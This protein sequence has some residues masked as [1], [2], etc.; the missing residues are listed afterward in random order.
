MLRV[1]IV[2]DTHAGE[3]LP[4]I[5]PEIHELLTG[6]EV[7]L[8]AGD[9]TD[10]S[11]LDGLR[12]VAPVVAVCGDHDRTFAR[13]RLPREHVLEIAGR[14]IG[15]T[16][17]NRSR[18]VEYLARISTLVAGRLVD[19]GLNR[20]LLRRFGP[21][22][23]IVY[24]H[25]HLPRN[26]VVGRTLIFSPGAGFTPEHDPP[27]PWVGAAG[28]AT[29]RFRRRLPAAELRAAV[30]VLEIGP[31]GLEARRLVLSRPLRGDAPA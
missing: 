1:G 26:E 28:R 18:V 4:R 13:R 25:L 19:L 29:G 12:A 8:H 15:V 9:I 10:L 24:G 20:H 27:V 3:H 6:C 31:D 11:A 30:G 22:D 2:A 21:L 7:I 17:G 23:C 16:H 5:A 14:R